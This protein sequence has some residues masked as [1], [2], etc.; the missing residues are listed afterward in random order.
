MEISI[1][2]HPMPKE[3]PY[4]MVNSQCLRGMSSDA[5]N[6]VNEN[7]ADMAKQKKKHL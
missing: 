2:N 6:N 1:P 3:N 7:R 5:M 4:L